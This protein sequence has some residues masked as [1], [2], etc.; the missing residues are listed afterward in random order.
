ML[1]SHHHC[2]VP[3]YSHHGNPALSQ[4]PTTA[5]VVS[6]HLP[7]WA[8]HTDGILQFWH[9]SLSMKFL[10]FTHIAELQSFSWPS[11]IPFVVSLIM[12]I[13]YVTGTPLD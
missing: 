13:S 1:Y 2:L 3:E 5:L 6:L 4:D 12:N 11:N 8:F 10:R 7:V 9:F